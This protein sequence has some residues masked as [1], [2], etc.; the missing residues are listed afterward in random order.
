MTGLTAAQIN[1]GIKRNVRTITRLPEPV[2]RWICHLCPWPAWRTGGYQD[3][4]D[5]YLHHH[6]ED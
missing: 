6:Q 4:M 1:T 5:H 2:G 3:W